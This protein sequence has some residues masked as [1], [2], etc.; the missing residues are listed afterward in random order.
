MLTLGLSFDRRFLGVTMLRYYRL[1]KR[2]VTAKEIIVGVVASLQAG[3]GVVALFN[4]VG[5]S[6]LTA[7][8]G[9]AHT[10]DHTQDKLKLIVGLHCSVPTNPHRRHSSASPTF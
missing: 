7:S 4:A 1:P 6:P 3:F 5:V 9:E 8:R 2:S 10:G